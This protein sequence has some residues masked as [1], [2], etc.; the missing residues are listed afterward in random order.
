MK[1]KTLYRSETNTMLGGV[2]GGLADYFN[3]DVSI[4]RIIFAVL[5]I[6]GSGSGLVL[7]IILWIILPPESQAKK[8]AEPKTEQKKAAPKKSTK[9]IA[10]KK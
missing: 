9:T 3:I 4:I 2:S 1:N 6:F 7:Y 10:K 5:A 8:G